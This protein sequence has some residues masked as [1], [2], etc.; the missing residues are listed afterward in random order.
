MLTPPGGWA[1]GACPS[2][3][4][5]ATITDRKHATAKSNRSGRHCLGLRHRRPYARTAARAA[6]NATLQDAK[7]RGTGPGVCCVKAS[8]FAVPDLSTAAVLATLSNYREEITAYTAPH[9][10]CRNEAR[11]G[12]V[13]GW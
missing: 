2:T 9:S 8:A 4:H 3:R 10:S 6:A 11:S 7:T 1:P 5:L 12:L 13:A